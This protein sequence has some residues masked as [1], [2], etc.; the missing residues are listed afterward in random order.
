MLR[1]MAEQGVLRTGT[2]GF[3]ARSPLPSAQRGDAEGR[4]GRAEEG[5]A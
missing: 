4:E 3:A 5:R 2:L 1:P